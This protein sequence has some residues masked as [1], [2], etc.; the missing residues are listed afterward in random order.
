MKQWQKFE[1]ED[2]ELYAEVQRRGLCPADVSG[3]PTP[4]GMNAGTSLRSMGV[5]HGRCPRE[6][7]DVTYAPTRDQRQYAKSRRLS[8]AE[9]AEEAEEWIK[10]EDGITE[11]MTN[12]RGVY[13][14]F[15]ST[16]PPE[17]ELDDA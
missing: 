2:P 11:T 16:S 17:N 3:S 14:R 5:Q 10:S 15:V 6:E 1:E 9:D 12:S 7:G 13:T 4:R 8:K